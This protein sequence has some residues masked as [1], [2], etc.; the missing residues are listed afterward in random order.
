MSLGKLTEITWLGHASFR[1]TRPG[2]EVLLLD[3]WLEGN[4]TC[5]AELQDPERVD[6]ILVTHGHPDHFADVVRLAKKHGARVVCNYEIGL[7]LKGQAELPEDQVIDMNIGGSVEVL[8]GLI[9]LMTR[10]DHTSSIQQ[11]DGS[12]V[13]GGVPCGFVLAGEDIA[14]IYCAGDT[15]AFGEMMIIGQQHEPA[16]ALLPIGGRFTMDPPAAAWAANM[17]GVPQV[18]PCHYGTFPV[19]TG[20]PAQL[21]EALHEL[22]SETG[23]IA[24]E[25]G[26]SVP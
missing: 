15:A 10:A 8:P 25:P 1:F 24:L 6:A 17:L 12:V 5:P 4:P 16:A 19:L 11:E 22:G 7:W 2:G 26:Q 14:T 23:V 20:T 13:P 21:V 18:V 3:P 9:A